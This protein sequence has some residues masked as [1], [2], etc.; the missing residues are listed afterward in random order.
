MRLAVAGGRGHGWRMDARCFLDG[1]AAAGW[2]SI[3][4]TLAFVAVGEFHAE[5]EFGGVVGWKVTLRCEARGV[6]FLTDKLKFG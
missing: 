6:C 4:A 1:L 3:G 5:T 2:R